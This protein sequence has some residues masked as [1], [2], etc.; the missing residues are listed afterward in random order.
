M[1][2]YFKCRMAK[3]R[4]CVNTVFQPFDRGITAVHHHFSFSAI[5]MVLVPVIP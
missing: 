1:G 4:F 3:R 2:F 5:S